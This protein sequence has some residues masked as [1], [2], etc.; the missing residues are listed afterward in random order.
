MKEIRIFV[1]L[2]ALIYCFFGCSPKK[3]NYIGE[4]CDW[5]IRPYGILCYWSDQ[6]GV[7]GKELKEE[8]LMEVPQSSTKEWNIGVWWKEARDII[9]VKIVYQGQITKEFL[10]NS[11]IQYWVQNWPE[12]PP[13]GHT[14]EDYVDDP[15]QGRWVTAHTYYKI[16]GDTVI[17][18][19]K[20]LLEEENE[21]AH[22]LPEP[23]RYRRSLKIRIL[24]TT[25]PPP[26][27]NLKVISPTLCKKQSIRIQ[28]GCGKIAKKIIEGKAEIF[29]GQINNIQGWNWDTGDRMTSNFSWIFK[30]KNE[31]K[32]IVADLTIAEPI[33]GGSTDQTIVTIR[34]SEGNFSFLPDDLKKGPIYIPAYSAYITFGTDTAAFNVSRIVQGDCIRK[35]LEIEPEQTYE[36]AR[37]EI[38]KLSVMEREQIGR[39]YIPLAVDASWQKFGL[40]WGGNIFMSKFLTKAKGNEVKRCA[41]N[42]DRFYWAIGTGKEPVYFRDDNVS[43]LS[44][45]HDYLPVAQ[46]AWDHEGLIYNEEAFVTLLEGPLSPYDP[47]RSEQTA[48]I[49]MI[50]L[51]ISNPT[52]QEKI[53]HVWIKGDPI[54]QVE[55]NGS[56]IVDKQKDKSYIRS[57]LKFS[58]EGNDQLMNIKKGAIYFPITIPANQQ[59]SIFIF[60]PFVGDLT[61]DSKEKFLSL[62]FEKER[63][64]VI[65]YWREIVGKCVA[66]NVPE[67]KFNDMSRS[68]V[69]HIRISTTKDPKSNLF[70]VPAASFFYMVFANESAFQTLYL[71]KIG[72]HT[73]AASYLETFLRLQGADPL[74]GTYTGDQSG[75]F[76]GAKVDDV[77]NYTHQNY[78]LDHGTVLW[79]LAQHYLLSQDKDWLRHAAPNMLKAANWIIEQRKQTKVLDMKG[80]TV[81]HYG[82]LPAGQ[83]ED[84]PDWAFWFANN[85]YACLGLLATAEAF[86]KGGLP[87]AGR[88][89]FEAQDYLLDLR[90]SIR[91]SSELCPL[92]QLQDK[93]YVPYVPSKAY[94]RFR[95]FGPMQSSYYSRFGEGES[96]AFRLYRLS[97]TREVLYGP[98]ILLTT[99]IIE[100]HSTLADAI[101]DDWEDNITLSSSLG[102]HIHGE[103]EDKYWFS[104]GGMVFQ[105]NLQNPIQAYLFRNEIPAAI[106]NIY[107]SMVSCLYPEVNAFTEEY[108]KWG[109][110]SGP[111]Y[112]TPDEAK[113]VNRV[114]DLLAIEV[115]DELWLASGTPR[116]WLE[117]GK[118]VQLYGVST[119]YGEVSYQ[120]KCGSKPNTIEAT[121]TLPK[122]IPDKK[123]K[124]FV[125]SPFG[126]QIQSVLINGKVWKNFDAKWEYIILP[127]SHKE[128]HVLVIY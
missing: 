106:R 83:L 85:A 30:I 33:L 61:I 18:S 26:I 116:Y 73:T 4:K 128:L 118:I 79:A 13:A 29:N 95:Y 108:H 46:V 54:Q 11:K 58:K 36:R 113:F 37:R 69:S 76:H 20:P 27:H 115:G 68:V 109:L 110:G 104:R 64:R 6:T 2:L 44:I 50:K 65:A 86:K 41:W 111:M 7:I 9:E 82:L 107:N 5:N 62:D 94:Q 84:N 45:L 35:K 57:L 90:S 19:F 38:P 12:I 16:K 31:T 1:F 96:S 10:S 77:Y 119:V 51:K 91:R 53:S 34:S 99:G 123:T 114:I 112:K 103:V 102:Q 124:L 89:Q 63:Q 92:I 93:T 8:S 101:L 100:P 48:A 3:D 39:L 22:N 67:P 23:V 126:K 71:D 81:L 17:Y 40:E 72:A 117:P 70:M 25:K 52:S 97:A 74:I 15:W 43:H 78:G 66:F 121:L 42:G 24:Y 75:V 120:I 14:Y 49:M 59:D 98:M 21:R 60:I 105:P 125:R 80:D 87:E 127:A 32:G 122:N 47:M 55:L 28:F 56:F 88:L